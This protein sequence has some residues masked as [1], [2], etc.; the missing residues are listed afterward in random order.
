M[1]LAY[2][3]YIFLLSGTTRIVSHAI[4]FAF[5]KPAPALYNAG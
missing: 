4:G 1:L 2:M 3:I 5:A